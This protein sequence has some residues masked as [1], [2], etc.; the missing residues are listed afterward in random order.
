MITD[1][2]MNDMLAMIEHLT[3]R[4]E[5]TGDRRYHVM[6]EAMVN[7]YEAKLKQKLQDEEEV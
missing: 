6:L 5:E 7:G 2:Y 3:E 1:N 4:L